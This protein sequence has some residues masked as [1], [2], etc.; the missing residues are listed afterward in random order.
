MLDMAFY[1]A[2]QHVKINWKITPD[3]NMIGEWNA[4]KAEADFAGRRWVAWFAPE[5]LIQDGMFKFYGLPGLIVKIEDRS[6]FRKMELKGIE[7]NVTK[8]DVLAFVFENAIPPDGKK[9]QTTNKNHRRDPLADFRKAVLAGETYMI[10]DSGKEIKGQ[11]YIKFQ[12]K[13]IL[14]RM[15]KNNN[16]LEIDWLK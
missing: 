12:E 11:N 15:K 2:S 14:G 1:N 5:I 3:T 6:G 10:D 7:N 13:L 9:Y 16:T 8:R 4:Q